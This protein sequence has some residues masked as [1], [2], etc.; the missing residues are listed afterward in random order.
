MKNIILIIIVLS[1]KAG[2]AQTP[3]FQWI[4][5][6]GSAGG[7]AANNDIYGKDIYTDANGNIYG[8]SQIYAG[9][10]SIDTFSQIN[11]YGGDDFCV[12]SYNCDGSLRWLRFFGSITSD[13]CV[14]MVGDD[15]GNTFLTGHILRDPFHGNVYYGDSV[16]PPSNQYYK[17]DFVCKIDSSGHTQWISFPGEANIANVNGG[18]VIHKIV[19]NNIGNPQVLYHF[20]DSCTFGNIT[21]PHAGL[22]LFDIDKNNGQ[23]L[24]VLNLNFRPENLSEGKYGLS[25]DEDNNIY[26][27]CIV[28][29]TIH[30]DTMVYT[31]IIVDSAY[32]NSRMLCKISDQG[33]LQWITTVSGVFN[34]TTNYLNSIYGKPIISGNSIYIGGVTQA[35]NGTTF[36]G[37]TI[38]NNFALYDHNTTYLMAKFNK[39]T[40]AFIN[41]LNLQNEGYMRNGFIKFIVKDNKVISGITGGRLVGLDNGDTIKPFTTQVSTAYPIVVSMDTSLNYFNWGIAT[42]AEGMPYVSCNA[43]DQRGNIYISGLMQDKIETSNGTPVYPA[44]TGDN[45]FIAKIATSNSNCGCVNPQI[46]AKLL[47]FQN[48]QLSVMANI[49]NN[50]DSIY[51]YW[52]DG[53]SSKY[54]QTGNPINHQY[55]T[56]GPFDVTLKAW[57]PCGLSDTTMLGLYDNIIKLPKELISVNCIPNPFNESLQIS[58]KNNKG[59]L[60]IEIYD[61]LGKQVLKTIMQG[62]YLNIST[63]HLKTGCYIIKIIKSGKGQIVKKLIK[64]E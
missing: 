13:Y 56:S 42:V 54:T 64:S 52:G 44:V 58:S 20:W 43:I 4:V 1:L 19:L 46:S 21:I 26:L 33:K 50:Y 25:M 24:N 8:V 3:E 62:E 16:V 39:N 45:F 17:Y 51:W 59:D 2:F 38:V 15:D 9:Y 57:N 32:Y 23:V 47:S 30:I 6:G 29:D 40:G 27:A 48:N 11:G 22:Y 35:F 55:S 10:T 31:D 61:L 5:N 12:Y 7:S 36:M 49:S 14:G 63:S 18:F 28:T 60:E 41:A 34:S 37:D 53:D